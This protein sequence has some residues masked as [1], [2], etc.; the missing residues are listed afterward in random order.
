LQI[1]LA[2]FTILSPAW[3]SNAFANSGVFISAPAA[4][5][6][7]HADKKEVIARRERHSVAS[8][9]FADLVGGLH[10]FVAGLA[11]ECFRKLGRIHQCSRG[12]ACAA[13]G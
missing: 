6:A 10:H 8:P 7:Q 12:L 1:S 4:S 3:Q 5:R 13:R 11:V 2:G 9:D